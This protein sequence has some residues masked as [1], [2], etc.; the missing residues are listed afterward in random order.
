MRKNDILRLTLSAMFLALCILLP[1]LT[2]QDQALGK[3]LS[4]MHIPVLLC[5]F[6]CGWP[7]GL[8]VGFIAPLLRSILF[9]APPLMPVAFAM[10]FELAA[11]GTACG[12]LYMLLPR[13]TPYIYVTLIVS[14]L[15]GRVVWGIAT[16]L[17]TLI[18]GSA[19]T[20]QMFWAGA[21]ANAVPGIILHILLIPVIILALRRA[22][23]IP[24]KSY[25]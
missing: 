10:A 4:L 9:G 6:I 24:L 21:F 20:L 25:K 23:L 13:K 11:Y 16:Y 3:M 1:F 17:I 18:S 5:G 15:A 7:Y 22:K 12:L 19:F 14:M 8:A 2:G